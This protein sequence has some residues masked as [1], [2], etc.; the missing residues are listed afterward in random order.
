MN[1]LLLLI[2]YGIY[3]ENE[4]IGEEVQITGRLRI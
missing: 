3:I 4:D 2:I 1:A